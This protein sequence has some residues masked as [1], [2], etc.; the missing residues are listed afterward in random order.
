MLAC[1]HIFCY[2]CIL[3]WLVH[4]PT[5]PSCRQP[6]SQRPALAYLVQEMVD[7][8]VRRMEMLDPDGEGCSARK[9]QQE[10]RQRMENNKESL[11]YNLFLETS[12]AGVLCNR[13]DD[14]I[15]CMRCCWEIEGAVCTHCGFQFSD[16]NFDSFDDFSHSDAHS[17]SESYDVLNQDNI[18]F[19]LDD[20]ED[21]FI[22]DNPTDEI[23]SNVSSNGCGG[24]NNILGKFF[25]SHTIVNWMGQIKCL[26]FRKKMMP[27]RC[28]EN[29]KGII[30]NIQF[31]DLFILI[32]SG[33]NS[34]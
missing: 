32:D 26:L 19:K 4:K 10:Q 17:T 13:E 21:S 30:S 31:K 27:R 15:R 16:E 1:G 7:V 5:C 23:K 29:R 20:H 8:F 6:L 22:G 2:G 34:H 12:F 33:E 25:Q 28:K 14:V 11:F 9:H 3:D 24:L 18:C